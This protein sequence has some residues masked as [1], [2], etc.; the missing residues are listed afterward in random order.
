M[1]PLGGGG[2]QGWISRNAAPSVFDSPCI[3]HDYAN[4]GLQAPP[5]TSRRSACPMPAGRCQALGAAAVATAF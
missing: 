2:R 3:L 5:W 4:E 1:R